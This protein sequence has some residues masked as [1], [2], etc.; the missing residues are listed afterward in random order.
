STR[1][2]HAY[3]VELSLPLGAA[4]ARGDVGLVRFMARAPVARQESGEGDLGVVL[5]RGGQPFEK[6]LNLSV[7][8]GPEWALFEI[9][10]TVANDFAPGEAVLAFT[11]GALSQTIEVG[12]VELLHF[13]RRATVEQ[14]PKLAFTYKGREPTAA[15]RAAALAR[16][17]EIRTAPLSIRV[18]DAAGRP[19]A[20]ARVEA[21]LEQAE[22]VWGTAVD[23][24]FII[25]DSPDATRYRQLIPEFFNTVVIENG[26][27]WPTWNGGPAR[28]AEALR[29]L[30][31]IESQ[32]LRHRGHNLI[33][34]GWKFSPRGQRDLPDLATA[35]PPI[36]EARITEML[37]ATRGRSI[38]WDVVNEPLHERDYFDHIPE[39]AMAD[40][41][42]LARRLDPS[43]DLFINEYSM[44]NSGLS[45]GTIARYRELIGRLRRA[46]APIDGIGIQGHIGRQPRAPEL[47]LSDLALIAAEGLPVQITE[48]DVNT[49]D[50]AIQGDYTRD[51]LI[52]CYSHPVVTGFINWGFWQGKHWKPD[53]AMFRRDWS[54]KPNAAVWRD[55]V[56][57][58]WLTRIDETTTAEAPVSVRGHLGRYRVTVTHDGVISRRDVTLTRSG[59]ELTVIFP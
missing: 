11:F 5:Q 42:K 9:P 58:Q 50:E 6:S 34:P 22:F 2:R 33:W 43:A 8:P 46:G 57:G 10:F 18:H 31:W 19:L 7:G 25:A 56:L 30:D 53:A 32:N 17:Q 27:K 41:F 44:L 16:I 3:D 37:T 52:A 59:A 12:G 21:R 24:R 45:P 38:A 15:W 54:E 14:L 51:F 39:L 36:I 35:L 23:D 26:L 20:G 55:L 28:Q 40:W 48:F 13:A 4:L 29:A 1:G 47:V 49:T